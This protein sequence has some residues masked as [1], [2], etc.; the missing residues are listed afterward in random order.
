MA[1]S[2]FSNAALLKEANVISRELKK[3]VTYQFAVMHRHPQ[4]YVSY[5]ESQ[6]QI[7]PME[8]LTDPSLPL[9]RLPC[10]VVRV[11]D[12]QHNC[13]TFWSIQKTKRQLDIMRKLSQ[14]SDNP[15]YSQHLD[16][17]DPFYEAVPPSKILVGTALVGI[18]SS[19]P[20]QPYKFTATFLDGFTSAPLGTCIVMLQPATSDKLDLEVS[21]LDIYSVAWFRQVHLQIDAGDLCGQSNTD[22]ISTSSLLRPSSDLTGVVLKTSLNLPRD[23]LVCERQYLHVDLFASINS[24][25]LEALE[26]V[27]AGSQHTTQ[28][29]TKPLGRRPEIELVKESRHDVTTAV[30]IFE[31]NSSGK[32]SP[33]TVSASSGLDPGACV[34]YHTGL[35]LS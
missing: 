13:I 8:D 28:L 15:A 9:A 4:A 33:V 19:R 16:F 12:H 25:Y 29:P 22:K 14:L 21:A 24:E 17:G 18:P 1:A 11:S 6:Q 20:L 5:E 30:T 27:E 7:L 35:R 23:S 10:V 3:R 2:S 31:L 32:Y 26:R 34:E